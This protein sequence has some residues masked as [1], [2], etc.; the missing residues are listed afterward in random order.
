MNN[1]KCVFTFSNFNVIKQLITQ[2]IFVLLKLLGGF[3]VLSKVNKTHI[4]VGSLVY[5]FGSD[6]L[7]HSL[8]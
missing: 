5:D 7:F 8:L 2:E 1:T 4:A 3:L 6:M